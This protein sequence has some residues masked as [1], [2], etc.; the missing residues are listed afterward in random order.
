GVG[1]G[2]NDRT[3]PAKTIQPHDAR[4]AGSRNSRRE[5]ISL[6]SDL[7][8]PF[9]QVDVEHDWTPRRVSTFP[10]QIRLVTS[11]EQA[12]WFARLTTERDLASDRGV[13]RKENPMK[14]VLL[15]GTILMCASLMAGSRV[16]AAPQ[17]GS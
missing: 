7:G 13:R 12:P 1:P 9:G 14:S 17:G 3:I 4:T 5:V 2:R 6:V 15:F 11:Q 10:S 8:C 16:A